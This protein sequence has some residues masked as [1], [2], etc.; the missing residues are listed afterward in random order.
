[1]RV[2]VV[3]AATIYHPWYQAVS[4]VVAGYL[5]LPYIHTAIHSLGLGK[6]SKSKRPESSTKG[7][8]NTEEWVQGSPYDTFSK[9]KAAAAKKVA[10][11]VARKKL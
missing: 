5:V 10:S 8:E 2:F 11:P 6:R 7:S 9:Q 1:M 4:S 3:H